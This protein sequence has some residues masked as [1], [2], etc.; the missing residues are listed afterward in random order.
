MFEFHLFCWDI[1]WRWDLSSFHKQRNRFPVFIIVNR[2]SFKAMNRGNGTYVVLI[3]SIRIAL[4]FEVIILYYVKAGLAVHYPDMR[5]TFNHEITSFCRKNLPFTFFKEKEE[6]K[7]LYLHC[8]F[9]RERK[10][11][12]EEE[13]PWLELFFFSIRRQPLKIKNGRNLELKV[14]SVQ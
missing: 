2:Q 4:K 6:G 5:L 14:Q 7:Y 10:P 11:L 13:R 3:L 12:R 9:Y 8:R 1:T